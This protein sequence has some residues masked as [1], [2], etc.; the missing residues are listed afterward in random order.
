MTRKAMIGSAIVHQLA[1]NAIEDYEPLDFDFFDE[2]IMSIE[3]EEKTDRWTMFFYGAMNIYGNGANA[4][5]ISPNKKQYLISVKLYFECTNNT[6]E[7]KACILDLEAALELK[8]RK[9][10]VYSDL[11]LIIYQIKGE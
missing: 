9:I 10:D 1:D 7:Y 5:I 11:M 3:E 6:T 8:I 2:D 4:V